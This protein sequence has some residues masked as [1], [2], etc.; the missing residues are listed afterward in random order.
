[1][2][3]ESKLA[4]LFDNLLLPGQPDEVAQ[5]DK[6]KPELAEVIPLVTIVEQARKLPSYSLSRLGFNNLKASLKQQIR[7]QLRVQTN[8][9]DTSSCGKLHLQPATKKPWS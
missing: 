2:T 3:E 4:D 9:D 7:W 5:A 6:S 8:N 1:M